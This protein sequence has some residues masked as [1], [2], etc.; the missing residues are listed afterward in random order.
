MLGG[1]TS[2]VS[3][4]ACGSAHVQAAIKS[5]ARPTL[6]LQISAG[7][8]ER[9]Q[10]KSINVGPPAALK[11]TLPSSRFVR[12]CSKCCN[13]NVLY[14]SDC[15]SKEPAWLVCLPEDADERC[16]GCVHQGIKD[17][18]PSS[19]PHEQPWPFALPP[20]D[21]DRLFKGVLWT[22]CT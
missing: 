15:L 18:C 13:S 16:N 9:Q 14:T 2:V 12:R 20:H 6:H 1:T 22:Q 5:L 10:V 8:P 11:V 3:S 4:H 21:T 19:G 7:T 17:C